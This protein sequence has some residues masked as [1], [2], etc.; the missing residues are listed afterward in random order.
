MG[1]AYKIED[2]SYPSVTTVLGI[3]D[4]SNA[5]LPWAVN[6]CV[7]YIE[8]ALRDDAD[9]HDDATILETIQK[10]KYEWRK[11]KDEAADIGSEIHNLIEKYI[12]EGKDA[13]GEL[14]PE[15]ENG[16]L[17]FLEWESENITQWVE[18]ESTVYSTEHGFAGTL[19]AVA[20][21]KD[22]RTLLIDFKSSKGF[23]D[24]YGKQISAYAIAYKERTG[25][26]I[27]GGGVLRLDKV[28]GNPE[29]KDYSENM[30]QKGDAFLKLL[31]FYYAD[32][33]RR[34]KNNPFVQSGNQQ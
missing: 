28:T 9:R 18:S 12:K 7:K 6:C 13:I 8:D 16:F 22:G 27:D 31:E 14:R 30:E 5:L 10:A 11:V 3:L 19:D 33:K 34:L 25:K 1:R 32:K 4:K 26:D 15:V 29:W 17:A 23:Y 24:G 20:E 2:I 21:M